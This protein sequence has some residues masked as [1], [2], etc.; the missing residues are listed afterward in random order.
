MVVQESCQIPSCLLK[1]VFVKQLLIE[2]S[3]SPWSKAGVQLGIR[4]PL[5][6]IVPTTCGHLS[7][8]QPVWGLSE[9]GLKPKRLC[10]RPA[11]VPRWVRHKLTAGASQGGRASNAGLFDLYSLQPQIAKNLVTA[12]IWRNATKVDHCWGTFL[13]QQG[14]K[15]GKGPPL[16]RPIVQNCRCRQIVHFPVSCLRFC[17]RTFIK[18]FQYLVSKLPMCRL[19]TLLSLVQYRSKLP[20]QADRTLSDVLFEILVQTNCTHSNVFCKIV[21]NWWFIRLLSD[22]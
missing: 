7:D 17:L 2:F 9:A 22:V 6:R 14:G 11:L 18:I 5:T 1:C 19:N 10:L 20:V 21:H 3:A 8:V 13:L 16:R 15:E 4:Q 12:E